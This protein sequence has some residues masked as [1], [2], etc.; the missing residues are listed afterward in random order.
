[1]I[2]ALLAPV[3]D[4]APTVGEEEFNVGKEILK[5]V[6]NSNIE[7]PLIHLPKVF[8][9]DFSVT[10]HVFMLWLVA[11]IVFTVVTFI[12]RRYLKTGN[13]VPRGAANAL[14]AVVEFIRDTIVLPNVGKK[15]VDT[16]AP[17]VLTFFLF[18]FSANLIG[19]I[20]I[21]DFLAIVNHYVIHAG[22]ET[23]FG[24]LIHGSSTVTGNY[25]VT[26]AL[27]MVTFGAII[28]AGSKAHGFMKH[29][30][31]MVPHGLPFPI[32]FILVPIEILGMF[33]KPFALTMRLAANMTGGHIALLAVMS[34]VVLF[35]EMFQTAVA[36]IAAGVLISVPLSV[37]LSALE[38]IVVLVQ[39]YVFT[40]LSAVFIGMAINVHH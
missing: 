36:G 18:I 26:S 19:L 4:H 25:N 6:A 8:G 5:H 22:H 10:K 9:I 37:G 20:P 34:M 35:T 14:E 12:V 13:P 1:M 31:N 7:E 15:W 11:F 39:A 2:W 40:L 24:K 33:V 23:F 21:F 3:Q 38:L 17:L 32:Y 29:W 27:A 16:W 30:K 28:L